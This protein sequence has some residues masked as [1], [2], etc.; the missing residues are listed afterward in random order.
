MKKQA[1]NFGAEF[2]HGAVIDSDFS[3]RPFR[4]NIEGEWVE[5]R[6]LIVA[7]GASARWLGLRIGAEADRPRREF[8]APPAMAFSIAGRRSW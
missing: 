1:E 7:S 6:T 2:M 3:K 4:L 5:T 8:A